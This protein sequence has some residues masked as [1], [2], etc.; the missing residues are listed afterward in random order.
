M[1]AGSD[2]DVTMLSP[3]ARRN[4]GSQLGAGGEE[5]VVGVVAGDRSDD[6]QMLVPDDDVA[7][8]EVSVV[9]PAVNEELTIV[10]F[11]EWCKEGLRTSDLRGEIL[12]VDSSSDRTAE[13]ARAG[14]ARVL[15]T[16]KRGLGRAYID[17][18]PFI[19]GRYVVMGDADLTYDFRELGLFVDH[20]GPA[21]SSPWGRAGSDP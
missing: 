1:R 7:D 11:V 2:D 15:R 16:P 14:G 13:L 4:A 17:A 12:I 10:E 8:P 5:R 6:V 19:R 9:V 21:T 20:F 18:V 3:E